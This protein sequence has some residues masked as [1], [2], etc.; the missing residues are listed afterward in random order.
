MKNFSLDYESFQIFS[1]LK[2]GNRQPILLI[3]P[4]GCGKECLLRYCFSLDS[5]SQFVVVHCSAQTKCIFVNITNIF[6]DNFNNQI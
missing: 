5:D 2:N 3:G 6:E 4:D 1:L